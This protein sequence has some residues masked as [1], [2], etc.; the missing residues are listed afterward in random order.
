VRVHF[1]L[2]LAA[3]LQAFLLISTLVLPGLVFA[4]EPTPTD[5]P[6]PTEQPSGAPSSDPSSEPTT[7]PTAPPSA[8]DPTA[9]PESTPDPAPQ[10]SPTIASDKADYAPGELVTLTGANWSA[11][12][13]VHIYVNDELGSTWSRN[14][15]VSADA[16]G[17]LVDQFNLPNWFVSN[18]A[19]VATG[20]TSDVAVA[21]FT[22]SNPQTIAVAA[23]T[24]AT[25]MQ[26]S[27]ATYGDVTVVVGGNTNSCTVTLGV[28]PGLPAGTSAVFGTNPNTTTGA[29]IVTTFSVTTSGATPTGTYAFQVTGTNGAGCQGPGA[30]PSNALTLIVNSATIGTTT[31]VSNATASFGDAS[32]VLNATVTPASGPAVNSGSV[33]FTILDGATTIGSATTDSTVVSGAAS[34]AYALPP[35]TEA[36]GYTISAMYTP[37]TGFAGS[38]G[39]GTLTIDKAGS[40][41]VITCPASVTYDGTAQEPCTATATGAGGLSTSVT[42]VYGNNTDAG[43]ATADAS[44]GG[45]ANHNGSTATQKTFTIT[46][47]H[48]TAAITAADKVYDGNTDATYTCAL[49]GVVGTEDV[50]C[51]GTHPGVFAD[52]N[53]GTW[54]VTASGLALAG[55]AKDNYVLDNLSDTDTADI[56]KATA[57]CT[58]VGYTGAYDGAFHGASGSCTGA[59]AGGNADG[60]TLDLGATFKFVPGGIADWSFTGGANYNDQSGSVAIVITTAYRIDG[61]YKPVD[62]TAVS[63]ATRLYNMVK[64]GQTVPL[65]FRVFS[66][67][68]A[69][70][71]STVGIN[72][73]VSKVNCSSG[74]VDPTLLPTDATGGTSLRYADGSFIFNWN[75]PKG[76]SLCYKV[77]VQTEDLSTTMTITGVVG[78]VEAYFR[79]K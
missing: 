60:S 43:T 58:I 34:V 2:R 35:G 40:S 55:T 11:G 22:D 66:L 56:G 64:N 31:A 7:E 1:V 18:Y 25:V 15:D 30:T 53:V 73:L 3:A 19:V 29:N 61:F 38:T 68:G 48:L 79:T 12:E 74:E 67:A 28:T 76:A 4:D 5:S 26:G 20:T 36:K 27:T 54:T 47:K 42:V 49:S 77:L 69:E 21:S 10:A 71:T 50:T 45:D 8:P 14:V 13:S 44:Y 32:V 16:S 57:L 23:P 62:M 46:V 51:D 59:D 39:S 33:T 52:K 65:K 41:T 24:S 72:T 78:P 75:V 17:N 37:G 6:A 9:A 70:V 63:A